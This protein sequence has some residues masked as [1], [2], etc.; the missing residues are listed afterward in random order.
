MSD[1]LLR[2]VAQRA[3][4]FCGET[5]SDKY[6]ELVAAARLKLCE[7]LAHSPDASR[8]YLTTAIDRAIRQ[9]NHRDRILSIPM[10]TRRDRIARGESPGD[11]ER[12]TWDS[13]FGSNGIR[14]VEPKHRHWPDAENQWFAKLSPE[15][16]LVE[17]GEAFQHLQTFCSDRLDWE[18]I[19]LRFGERGLTTDVLG[20]SLPVHAADVADQ[21]GISTT[22]VE[23]R[24][25][26]IERRYYQHL[27]RRRPTQRRKQQPRRQYA[28][29][30]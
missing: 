20:A 3:A 19:K 12:R 14:P 30:A 4:R 11:L 27:G 5:G 28:N 6:Q 2:L 26:E 17:V 13:V 22:E 9:A 7:V 18:I 23:G 21:L 24:L 29:A 10:Q 25:E 16:E 1:S 15:C 8:A